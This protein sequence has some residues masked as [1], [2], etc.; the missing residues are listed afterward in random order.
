MISLD[1]ACYLPLQSSLCVSLS[2][3]CVSPLHHKLGYR[4]SKYT[5][6]LG[7]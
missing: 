5:L 1:D 2:L 3:I 6:H 4:N 7:V